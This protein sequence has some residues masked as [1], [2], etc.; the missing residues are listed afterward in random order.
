MTSAL[1]VYTVI[2]PMDDVAPNRIM[3]HAV[4]NCFGVTERKSNYDH[5][6]DRFVSMTSKGILSAEIQAATNL[7]CRSRRGHSNSDMR[8]FCQTKNERNLSLDDLLEH[9]M[10]FLS[11]P[12]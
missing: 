2:E 1:F 5:S 10:M 6:W 3:T 8:E 11:L 4:E 9:G 12:D 7:K